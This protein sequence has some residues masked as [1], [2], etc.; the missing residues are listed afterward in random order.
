M[1]SGNSI[2]QAINNQIL[3][4]NSFILQQQFMFSTFQ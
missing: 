3:L 1:A 2:N 4:S